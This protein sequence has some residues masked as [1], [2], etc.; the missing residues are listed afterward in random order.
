MVSAAGQLVCCPRCMAKDIRKSHRSS[1]WDVIM[2][3]LLASPLRCRACGK[4]FYKRLNPAGG[5]SQSLSS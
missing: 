3:S 5:G 2:Q 4:R 1:F